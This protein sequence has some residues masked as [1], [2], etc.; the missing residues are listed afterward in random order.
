VNPEYE[1][2]DVPEVHENA[3]E[4][5]PVSVT[6]SAL[7]LLPTPCPTIHLKT[8]DHVRI[9]MA[10]VYRDM[11]R[12]RIATQDGT[13]LTYVLSQI[14]KLIEAGELEKRIEAMETVLR[15]RKL[16]R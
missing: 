5:C 4:N 6:D 11:K 10:K 3:A 1:P 14:G 13:R 7:T 8:L 9:E 12:G 15:Q 16:P 2:E